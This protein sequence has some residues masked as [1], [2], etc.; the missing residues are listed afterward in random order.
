MLLKIIGII[1]ILLSAAAIGRELR[2][3][4]DR[5]LGFATA[6]VSL[7]SYTRQMIE[8]FNASGEEILRSCSTELLLECGY[9]G[10]RAPKSF[11]ELADAC[12]MGDGESARIFGEFCRGFGKSYRNEQLR[13]C[14]YYLA[15]L[16][17][18]ADRLRQETASRKKIVLV[19][20]VSCGLMLAILFI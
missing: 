16:T 9:I 5:E 3:A 20:A 7:L 14:E 12:E 11:S 19:S 17:E 18:R 8:N 4:L 1:L 2:G 13:H 6:R 10:D 15:L